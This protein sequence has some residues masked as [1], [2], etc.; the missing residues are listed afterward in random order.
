M[1]SDDLVSIITPAYNS[2]S[3]IEE[4]IR[5]VQEQ[6]YSNWELIIAD[7]CSLDRTAC[8]VRDLANKDNRIIYLKARENRG[9]A[10]SRNLAL[11]HSNGRYIA[12]LDSDDIWLEKKLD[13]QLSFMKSSQCAISYTAY[14]RITEDG[15]KTGR[16]IKI[17][18]QLS[19]N[20]L[21]SNT[22]I[23]TSTVMVDRRLT[24]NF[25]M[26]QTYYDDFALWLQIL[27][28]GHCAI[29]LDEDLV[30]YRVVD[31]SVSRKKFRSAS[32]VWKTYREIEK[33]GLLKSWWSFAGY[34]M[35]ALIKYRTF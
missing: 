31:N 23:V 7:D 1:Y 27:K 29:A 9:P 34:M 8:V 26:K 10:Q 3:F 32:M 33:L 5:S 18:K 4:T 11:Q 22:A 17:P 2:Q 12:F 16:L 15:N 6:N 21:L 13:R 20:A 25:R 19:Y 28:T 30:R 24:G 14:R 35:N